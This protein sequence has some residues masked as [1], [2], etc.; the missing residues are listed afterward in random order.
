R[1]AWTINASISCSCGSAVNS[2][3]L[4]GPPGISAMPIPFARHIIATSAKYLADFLS[5]LLKTSFDRRQSDYS[6]WAGYGHF[7]P[8]KIHSLR[9]RKT[10]DEHEHYLLLHSWQASDSL[11]NYFHHFPFFHRIH[12]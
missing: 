2:V 1:T 4:S 7:L 10:L 3:N 9:I 5:R 8:Q 6:V 12:V 11:I